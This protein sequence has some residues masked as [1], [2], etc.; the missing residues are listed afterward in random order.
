MLHK[1]KEL[2]L[3]LYQMQTDKVDEDHIVQLFGLS[4]DWFRN[5]FLSTVLVIHMSRCG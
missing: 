5:I 4:P 1:F 3:I 2:S